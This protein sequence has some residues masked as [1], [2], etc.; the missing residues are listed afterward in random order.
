MNPSFQIATNQVMLLGRLCHSPNLHHGSNG[1]PKASLQIAV[2]RSLRSTSRSR[3]QLSQGDK[4][5]DFITV[6]LFGNSA[7]EL[8]SRKLGR[9]TWVNV[10]GRLRTR[11]HRKWEVV[12]HTVAPIQP[13]NDA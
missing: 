3:A 1:V 10:R 13:E 8:H 11:R 12:A 7:R 6:V 2:P 5:M 9:G 4:Q